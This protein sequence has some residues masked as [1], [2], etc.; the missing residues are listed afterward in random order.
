MAGAPTTQYT[1]TTNLSATQYGFEWSDITGVIAGETGSSYTALAPGFYSVKVTN[2]T[3]GCFE[4]GSATI[5]PSLPPSQ[6]FTSVTSYFED[7]QMVSISVTP[8]GDYLYQLDTGLF[9]GDN[10]FTNLFSGNHTVTVKDKYGCGTAQA[11]FRIVNYPKFFTPNGDG[12]NDTWNIAE[13]ATDQPEAFIYI[14]DRYGKLLKQISVIGEGWDGTLNGLTLPSTDYW[15]RVF[16]K[17]NGESKEFKS[18]FSLKR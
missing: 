7:N 4:T 3:T 11:T 14:F 9:Q 15:F 17:E 2:L 6:V 16:Y 8:P 1:L 13:I 10:F 5:V 12:Y 18:H